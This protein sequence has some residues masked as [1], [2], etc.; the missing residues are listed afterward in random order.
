[1]TRR[2]FV[3]CPV[4]DRPAL[5]KS[6]LGSMLEADGWSRLTMLDNGSKKPTQ[7]LLAEH[8]SKR[9]EVVQTGGLSIYEQW[10]L[11]FERCRRAARGRPFDVLVTNNDIE[12]PASA[13]VELSK[14]LELDPRRFVAYPDYDWPMGRGER[15]RGYR[16]TSG[17]LGEGG[18]FGACFMVAGERLEWV[19]PEVGLISD[20]AYEWWYGD[21]HLARQVA[22]AGG[23]QVR[24]VGLPVH[25]VGGG[26]ARHHPE[27]ARMIMRDRS[28]WIASAR[29]RDTEQVRRRRRKHVPGTIVWTP[30]GDRRV[31]E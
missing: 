26:T 3:I 16:E 31:V 23:L 9:V 29:G 19:T 6:F 14:A 2:T 25:H 11:G 17:V 1:M 7:D 27:T 20:T 28:R 5:T 8:A 18:M 12:L 13:I 10:N 22:E 30:G 21:N 15:V 24:C 4:R